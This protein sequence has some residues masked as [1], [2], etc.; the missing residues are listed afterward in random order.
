MSS[1]DHNTHFPALFTTQGNILS[2]SCSLE[3]TQCSASSHQNRRLCRA[4]AEQSQ[5]AVQNQ[6]T[7]HKNSVGCVFSFSLTALVCICLFPGKDHTE[8]GACFQILFPIYI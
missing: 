6:G 8:F 2:V 5:E 1:L 4:E 7:V 3:E